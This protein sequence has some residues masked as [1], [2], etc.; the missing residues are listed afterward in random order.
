MRSQICKYAKTLGVYKVVY[1]KKAKRVAGT[2]NAY[3]KLIFLNA[4]QNRKHL[5][6]S[7]FHEIGH[8]VACMRELWT[9]YHF[10]LKPF[11]EETRFL[12][13]NNIDKIA[14]VL[15]NKSVCNK[16]WGKYKYYYPISQKKGLIKWLKKYNNK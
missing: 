14:N 15:W 1:N 12:I 11:S 8:H 3:R 4:K 13:E 6:M 5:L 10:D 7:F 16:T 9:D 2:Y